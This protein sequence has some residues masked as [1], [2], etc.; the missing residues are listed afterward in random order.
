MR[1]YL[2]TLYASSQ[3]VSA[4][5]KLYGVPSRIHCNGRDSPPVTE[6]SCRAWDICPFCPP[7]SNAA[8]TRLQLPDLLCS[9]APTS[10]LQPHCTNHPG[11]AEDNPSVPSEFYHQS[12]SLPPSPS[13]FPRAALFSSSF[14]PATEGVRGIKGQELS[15]AQAELLLRNPGGAAINAGENVLRSEAICIAACCN[16]FVCIVPPLFS[17]V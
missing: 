2:G 6:L 17:G 4:V 12:P 5:T 10:S 14:L 3:A 16:T 11:P 8:F 13:P 15:E 1:D 7:A 9:C